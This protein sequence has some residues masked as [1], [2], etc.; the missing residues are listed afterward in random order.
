MS[1]QD[2]QLIAEFNARRSEAAFAALVRQ[3][4]NL[5]FATAMRQ[6]GDAGAAEEITQNVFVALAQAAGRLGSHP[7]IAGWLHQTAL[8]K[9]REWLRSELRRR[10]REQ[11][12]VN[13]DLA[14]AE[15]D[16][17]WSPLVPLLDDALL[18]LR[19]PDRQAVILH[20]LEG[21]T[22]QEVGSALGIGEDTARKRV[23]RCLDQL[24]DFFRRRGFAV[25]ALAAGA[26]LF[27][28]SSHAA[29]AGLAASAT[30]AGLM[31]HS[32]ISTLTLIKG[33]LKTMAWTKAKTAIVT[34]AAAILTIATAVFLVEEI[35]KPGG[36]DAETPP[37]STPS[38]QLF[39]FDWRFFK[40]DA[41]NAQTPAFD[42]LQWRLLDLPHDWSLEDLPAP[43]NG[44]PG[45][46]IISGPFDSE[47]PGG[48]N[49][50]FT[51]GGTGWYRKHF[52]A[53]KAWRG[54]VVTVQFDGVYMNADAWING[55]HLGNHPYGYTP[56]TFDLSKS[57]R[58]GDEENVLAVRVRNEGLNSRWYAGSGIYR[59]VWLK[60]T[61]QVHIAQ[62]RSFVTTPEVNAEKSRVRIQT[63]LE[64]DTG[65]RGDFTLV[66][67]IVDPE[68]KVIATRTL[69]TRL[70]GQGPSTVDQTF[71]AT[72]PRLWS[73]ES[74]VLY[75][76]VCELKRGSETLDRSET[77][78]GIR[79][80]RFD[81]DKGFFLN[82]RNLKLKGG[83]VHANNGPLGAA[84]FDRAEE[85]RVELLKASGFNAIRCA[86]NP[87]STAFLDA[88]DRL[89][90]MVIDETFDAWTLPHEPATDDYHLFFKKWWQRDLESVIRRDRNHP[91]IILWSI[92][93]QITDSSQD[94]G[95]RTARQL[96]A[97]T[98]SLDPTRPVTANVL[99]RSGDWHDSDPFAAAL[100]VCGYSY[101]RANYDEDHKR[102]PN[103]VMFTSEINP[104]N[105]FDNWMAVL[106]RNF[107]CGNFEWTAFDY[108]GE[109]GLGW[110]SYDRTAAELFPWTV[111][112]SG[113]LDI[114]GFKRPRSYY[115]DALWSG[116]PEVSAF[117]HSPVPSFP[118]PNKSSWGWDDV[119]ASWTWPGCEEKPLAVDVYSSC[120]RVKLMLNGKDLGTKP[121]T[122]ETQFKAAW[123]VPYESGTLT[124][125]GF[126]NN[127]EAARWELPTAGPPVALRLAADRTTLKADGQDLCCVVVEVVDAHGIRDPNAEKLVRF[128]VEGAGIL[129]AVGNSKP[130]SLESFR[131]PQRTTHDG[132]CLVILKSNRT[133]GVI[134]LTAQADSLGENSVEIKTQAD[135]ANTPA[136]E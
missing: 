80:I 7:S 79:S 102:L 85:R 21:R 132:R 96:A 136:T 101:A 84:A 124:A 113:D 15:G 90:M 13:L 82:G 103:R 12:A 67:T 121:T 48:P 74:P 117:V 66:T 29:P 55:K 75:R 43:A 35:A 122:R 1:E 19:E 4:V 73:P 2:D 134:K 107:V 91:S 53:P 118:G 38:T 6:V 69:T 23:H 10:K 41:R 104:G 24:T 86:H 31:A 45:T 78:F 76:A 126:T 92:G 133:P 88:C 119:K 120:D 3:H 81:A 63:T 52:T 114:C 112:Y 40:G 130:T 51:V 57:L 72:S 36:S 34:G 106:D 49:T 16:S 71:E 125:I 64:N 87:P 77:A 33:A 60:A 95:A 110:R 131:Q 70:S 47:A 42:D 105:S 54:K 39:D 116:K 99:Q 62:G 129:A 56:F 28:L 127:T 11:A 30:S 93:N 58:F 83:C 108:M 115:R 27:A 61:E 111:S 46:R 68:S 25:P 44:A 32:T 8:N 26:P 109:A 5:V 97:Y 128:S 98:R 22:F 50:G 89:G 17:V 135:G 100:D 94:S 20:F 59:H 14:R 65:K 9:S 123:Q 18:K 37:L